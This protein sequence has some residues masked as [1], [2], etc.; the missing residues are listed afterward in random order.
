V[1]TDADGDNV[2]DDID[3]CLGVANNK[4]Q[5]SDADG[6]GDACD[7]S[8]LFPVLNAGD[9]DR[10][11]LFLVPALPSAGILGLSAVALGGF[12]ALQRRRASG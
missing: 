2:S 6:V 7:T 9:P 1:T 10:L 12:V 3:N 5:N 11:N 4:Q 8:P